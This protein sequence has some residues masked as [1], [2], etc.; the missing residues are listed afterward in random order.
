M[1]DNIFKYLS[2][3]GLVAQTVFEDELSQALSKEQISFYIGIDPTADSLHIGHFL[4]LHVAKL[5]Q[6]AGHKPYLILGGGTGHVGD[7]SGRADMRQ[8]MSSDKIASNV[9]NFEKQIAKFLSFDGPNGAVFINNADWLLQLKWIDL[10]RE[11][12]ALIS[13]NKMLATD[14]YKARWAN[15]LSFLELNYMVMQAYDFLHLNR[16]F[17]VMLQIGGNDQWS[18]ILAGVDLIRR[19]ERK[20]ANGLTVPLLT[21]SDG[22]KMGKTSSGALWLDENKTPVYDFY[23]YWIN[24]D[25][26]DVH[27]LF[28]L[29]TELPE[30]Q[31]N[32]LTN[33]SGK[34]LVL[35]KKEL[36]YILTKTVHGADKAELAKMQATAAFAG[37]DDANMPQK[38]LQL[39]DKFVSTLLVE[40]GAAASKSEAR[41]L[42]TAGGILLNDVKVTDPLEKIPDD[43]LKTGHFI[44]HKG[45]KFHLK[46]YVSI[47][48]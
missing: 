45:K 27:K 48:G 30:E 34:E 23:Q 29:L 12:G 28:M 47:K 9:K 35:A 6:K 4:M 42:I 19:L 16:K 43:M 7:P 13:V 38:K 33:C 31:I 26:R 32:K 41:R 21:K 5:L 14:A 11:V 17:N 8:M 22:T 3:R 10:L 20:T 36:A 46:V 15:G 2:T 44:L 25:D 1:R 40:A 18:N 37:N 39:A 24:V